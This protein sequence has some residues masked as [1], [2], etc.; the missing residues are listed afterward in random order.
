MRNI[1]I[2]L[3]YDGTNYQGWQIQPT[4]TTIQGLLTD[5][6]STLD[7]RPVVV[8][9]A[10]RTDAGVHAEGQVANFLFHRPMSEE[11]LLR[12]INGNLPLD[13]RVKDVA[14]VSPEF[15]AR[16]SAKSKTYRY[17]F[18]LGQVVSPFMYRYVHRCG[19]SLSLDRIRAAANVLEGRHDFAAFGTKNHE[20]ATTIRHIMAIDVLQEGDL[21]KVEITADGFL[22]SMMRRIAGT[23]QDVG[24]GKLRLDEVP[25]MLEASAGTEAGPALPAKGLTLVRVGY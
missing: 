23:L 13:V 18:F 15:H 14:E 19:F 22:R 5:I 7:G 8:H 6:L 16:F 3:E 2:V 25:L 4:G 9:G 12:A 20:R 11:Q 10:G 17:T 1:K 21:L 24:R